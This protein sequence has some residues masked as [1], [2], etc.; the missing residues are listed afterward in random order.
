MLTN[1]AQKSPFTLVICKSNVMG[2]SL[3]YKAVQSRVN[4]LHVKNPTFYI[5][6]HQNGSTSYQSFFMVDIHGTYYIVKNNN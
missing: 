6:H 4:I 2:R 1:Y 3:H 5:K